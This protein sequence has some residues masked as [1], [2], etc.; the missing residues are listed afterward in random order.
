MEVIFSFTLCD[1]VCFIFSFFSSALFQK[2]NFSVLTA[3]DYAT[4]S[5]HSLKGLCF[6]FCPFYKLIARCEIH[7]NIDRGFVDMMRLED[8]FV[9]KLEENIFIVTLVT[10]LLLP[11]LYDVTKGDNTPSHQPGIGSAHWLCLVFCIWI[12]SI[13]ICLFFL[14]EAVNRRVHMPAKYHEVVQEPFNEVV[15]MKFT[16]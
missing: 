16:S 4:N 8:R 11:A 12:N 2:W 6:F 14:L 7:L 15:G 10:L 9:K 5:P 1:F 13:P 3:A